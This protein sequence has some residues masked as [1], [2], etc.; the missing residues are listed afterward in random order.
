MALFPKPYTTTLWFHIPS[1]H[2][3]SRTN[4]AIIGNHG[5]AEDAKMPTFGNICM[6]ANKVELH[7]IR[8]I[9][10]Q[11]IYEIQ[12]A[13]ANMAEH[14]QVKHQLIKNHGIVYV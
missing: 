4:R 5:A 12:T 1:P 8:W 13:N 11:L 10:L 9:K 3:Y 6:M 14:I 2:G 7:P